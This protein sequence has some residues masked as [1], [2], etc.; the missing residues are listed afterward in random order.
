VTVV[1]RV[2]VTVTAATVM[3]AMAS[4]MVTVMMPV[5]VMVGGRTPAV[6]GRARLDRRGR[7]D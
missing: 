6:D 4:A 2:T 5:T 1:M 3:S 7:R